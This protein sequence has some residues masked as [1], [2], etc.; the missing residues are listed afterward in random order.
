MKRGGVQS[1]SRLSVQ[2][3]LHAERFGLSHGA[4]VYAEAGRA[5]GALVVRD[6]PELFVFLV[7]G[8]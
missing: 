8:T 3:L 6:S 2:H 4:I 7:F 1:L 5:A